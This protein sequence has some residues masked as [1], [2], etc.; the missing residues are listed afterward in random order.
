MLAG[1][2]MRIIISSVCVSLTHTEA[3][4]SENICWHILYH[5]GHC[6][7]FISVFEFQN[8]ISETTGKKKCM[9]LSRV[10]SRPGPEVIKLFSC[11][12]TEHD[13]FPA[14]KC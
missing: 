2:F 7:F 9:L 13:F 4:L 1:I 3:V 14:H 5:N 10:A 8:V 12:T 11:S 6:C